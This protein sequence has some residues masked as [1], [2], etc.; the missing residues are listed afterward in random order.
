VKIMI[1]LCAICF[2]MLGV[3]ILPAAAADRPG[4]YYVKA[5]YVGSAPYYVVDHGPEISGPGIMITEIRLTNT[6]VRQSYP[7]IRSSGDVT[8]FVPTTDY[9]GVLPAMLDTTVRT[10]P[11]WHLPPR[12]K[13]IRSRY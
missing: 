2:A 3:A 13:R 5:A 9:Y 11:R 10:T 7:Y 4:T 6:D 12:R 1:R 8:R